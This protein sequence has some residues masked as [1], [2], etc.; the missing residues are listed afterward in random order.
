ML[1]NVLTRSPDAVSSDSGGS[2]VG[3]LITASRRLRSTPG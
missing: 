2:A 1:R 3:D